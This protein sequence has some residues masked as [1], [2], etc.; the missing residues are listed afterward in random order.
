MLK[1]KC[2][3]PGEPATPAHHL[4]TCPH[5]DHYQRRQTRNKRKEKRRKLARRSR[6]PV[7]DLDAFRRLRFEGKL[8]EVVHPFYDQLPTT[9]TLKA[10]RRGVQGVIA[11]FARSKKL[12]RD[13]SVF[14]KFN[15][16]TETVAISYWYNTREV[17]VYDVYDAINPGSKKIVGMHVALDG[18]K[19]P[20]MK[21][22]RRIINPDPD[23]CDVCDRPVDRNGTRDFAPYCSNLCSIQ[24]D[25]SQ[26]L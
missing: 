23:L 8:R 1:L 21:G 16:R 10:M 2:A 15:E 18:S 19:R 11:D 24:V 6:S 9:A 5:S 20:V 26:P 17:Q 12:A 3:C 13:I 14:V 25:H 22:E 4:L 7:V